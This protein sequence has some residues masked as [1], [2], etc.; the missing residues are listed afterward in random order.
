MIM[1]PLGWFFAIFLGPIAGGLIAEAIHRAVGRRR[2]HWIGVVVVACIV[3][4]ALLP[5]APSLLG[6]FLSIA[7]PSAFTVQTWL[8]LLQV[9]NP[10]Y[11]IL[12]SITAYAR[13]R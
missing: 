10:V 1:R 3:V 2:G 8:A 11:V 9:S 13:L 7:N 5:A 4:S 12:A 6:V